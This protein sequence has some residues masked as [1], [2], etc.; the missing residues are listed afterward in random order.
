MT[1]NF[2]Q[3]SGIEQRALNCVLVSIECCVAL[4][5]YAPVDTIGQDPYRRRRL[6]R[7]STDGANGEREMISI[8]FKSGDTFSLPA[9]IHC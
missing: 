4:C 1:K 7:T 2:T 5:P 9:V 3:S 6:S 8:T